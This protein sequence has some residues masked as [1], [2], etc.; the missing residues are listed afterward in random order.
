MQEETNKQYEE[1]LS[2]I[3]GSVFNYSEKCDP[4]RRLTKKFIKED[5]LLVLVDEKGNK[6]DY[7][8]YKEE[9]KDHGAKSA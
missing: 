2:L 5:N 3:L 7:I 1:Y 9:E 8:K 6:N 4:N